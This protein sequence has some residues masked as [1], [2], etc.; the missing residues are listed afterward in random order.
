MDI[1]INFLRVASSRF[2][3]TVAHIAQVTEREPHLLAQDPKVLRKV[4]VAERL[5]VATDHDRD[6]LFVGCI[7]LWKL[8]HPESGLSWY[9][10]GTI[11][12]EPEY[13]YPLTGYSVADLLYRKLLDS[14]VHDNILATTTNPNAIK[15]GRRANLKMVRF[16][17]LPGWVEQATCICSANK[18]QT[19]QAGH[20]L[21]KDETC[22]VRLSIR[23]Y[24]R[25][26]RQKC[27]WRCEPHC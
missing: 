26:E 25:L 4:A 10:L 7:M 27:N 8:P 17:D 21:L 18:R 6:N 9:E 20:C 13:R 1:R 12:V 2:E 19:K 23:T 5:F 15:A 11:Y 16:S 24:W 22:R 14:F 3:Q